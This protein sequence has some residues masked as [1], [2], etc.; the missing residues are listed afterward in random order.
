MADEDNTLLLDNQ[1]LD[2]VENVFIVGY[3]AGITDAERNNHEA[4]I[5]ILTRQK[6][7]FK[8]VGATW[9]MGTFK[10]YHVHIDAPDWVASMTQTWYVRRVRALICCLGYMKLTL[11]ECRPLTSRI[12]ERSTLVR[13]MS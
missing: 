3:K 9:N 7:G 12:T 6:S 5:N 11:N 4:A 13:T 8:G 2:A 1:P 10:G